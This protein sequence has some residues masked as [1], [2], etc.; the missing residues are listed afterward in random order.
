MGTNLNVHV[1][2]FL[3]GHSSQGEKNDVDIIN[4]FC[5]TLCDAISKWGEIFVRAHLVCKFEKLE[6]GFCKCYRKVQIDEQVYMP[7]RMIKQ[8]GDKNMEVYYECML[9][10]VNY[11]QH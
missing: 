5:F 4:I 6:T 10:L 1:H 3:Q 11:L 8:G 2:I 7:L 9:N